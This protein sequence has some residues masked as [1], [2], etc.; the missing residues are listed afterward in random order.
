RQSSKSSQKNREPQY[1]GGPADLVS[2]QNFLQ[3]FNRAMIGRS[4]HTSQTHAAISPGGRP[5]RR[6]S[7][8]TAV[9]V[10]LAIACV[11][12]ALRDQQRP[13]AAASRLSAKDQALLDKATANVEAFVSAQKKKTN[14]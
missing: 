4:A 13:E 7:A 11:V 5:A 6:R 12:W 10:L 14:D 1:S 2:N 3:E 9:L 8:R